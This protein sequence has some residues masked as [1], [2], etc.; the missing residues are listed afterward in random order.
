MK[1][2]SAIIISFQCSGFGFIQPDDGEEEVFVHQV[3]TITSLPSS[4]KPESRLDQVAKVS[5]VLAN[6]SAIVLADF[7]SRS[8]NL[9]IYIR[10]RRRPD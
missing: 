10:A 3:R 4:G 5:F 9:N 8:Q 6:V 1:S 7:V 2:F